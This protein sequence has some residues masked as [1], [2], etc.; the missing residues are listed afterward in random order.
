M[1]TL[2]ILIF[3]AG[4]MGIALEHRLRVDK[5]AIAL[6]MFGSIWSVYAYCRPGGAGLFQKT[7]PTLHQ[8]QGKEDESDGSCRSDEDIGIHSTHQDMQLTIPIAPARA[9]STVM[10]ILRMFFQ[11]AFICEDFLIYEL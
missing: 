2:L 7:S 1:D 9:V 6:L 5:A 4:Y 11:F 8:C 3:I 10:M